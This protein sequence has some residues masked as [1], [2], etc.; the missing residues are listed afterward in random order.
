[1]YAY[2][3]VSNLCLTQCKNWT[4]YNG[5]QINADKGE[6]YSNWILDFRGRLMI[7]NPEFL[8]FKFTFVAI[9]STFNLIVV[10]FYVE[11]QTPFSNLIVV[12]P[13][14]F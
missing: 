3:K 9:K 6:K 4:E 13:G 7:T 12:N 8:A 14:S 2:Y 10:F 11:Q 1:M 5:H